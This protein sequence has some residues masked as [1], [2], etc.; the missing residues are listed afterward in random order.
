MFSPRSFGRLYGAGLSSRYFGALQAKEVAETDL[1][2][3]KLQRD[4]AITRAEGES[5]ARSLVMQAD[6]ALDKK[7]AAWVEVNKA[8]AEQVGKQRWVPDVVMGGTGTSGPGLDVMELFALKTAKDLA[9]DYR[10]L[11]SSKGN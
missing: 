8:F 3:A 9:V 1:Q 7:L 6:G 4:A 5:K 11:G 2:T 10:S